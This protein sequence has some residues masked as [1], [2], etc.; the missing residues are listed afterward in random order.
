MHEQTETIILLDNELWSSIVCRARERGRFFNTKYII[1]EGINMV[2]EYKE[3]LAEL[4]NE[5]A[6]LQNVSIE[7]AVEARMAEL[8]EQVVA[9]ETKK[10]E[11]AI[12]EK[13]LEIEATKRIIA[14]LEVATLE[15]VQ[16]ENEQKEGE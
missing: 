6:Q 3:F 15:V 9:E 12:Y 7:N 11:D 1:K 2:A 14:R 5:L 13:Q 4:E 10:K 16:D 8:R